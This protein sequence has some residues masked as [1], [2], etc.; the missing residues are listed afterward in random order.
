[1]WAVA[2]GESIE[3]RIVALI[4]ALGGVFIIARLVL[5]YEKVFISDQA[6]LIRELRD[7]VRKAREESE[8]CHIERTADR[9]RLNELAAELARLRDEI[10]R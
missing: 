5:R 6:V 2:F 3:A 9:A 10:E 7:D 4:G 8:R 1:M